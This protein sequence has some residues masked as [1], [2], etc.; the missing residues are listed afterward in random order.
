MP[1]HPD[2]SRLRLEYRRR[3]KRFSGSDI[4]SPFNPAHLFMV[5]QRQRAMLRLLR[6]HGFYPL[7]EKRILELGCGK[8]GVLLEYLG[9]GVSS[10]L[11]HG[12]DL[13]WDSIVKAR[14][15]LPHLPLTCADGQNLPYTSASFD[16]VLQFTVF[17]SILNESI[18]ANLASEMLRVLK[19]DGMILW[20]DFWLNPTNSQTQGIRP[21]EIRRLFPNSHFEFLRITLAPPLTRILAPVC[22]E[23]ALLL[24]NLRILNTHYLVSIR[25]IH[26]D[27]R[28]N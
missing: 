10:H 7:A 24:E 16:L 2:L 15:L 9:Y 3:E 25:P 18:K 1:E 6:R 14:H 27:V 19:P 17:S 23:M 13:L 28:N 26:S 8:G 22:W 4:Y 11:L 20:Y 5:Q 12:A 21:A